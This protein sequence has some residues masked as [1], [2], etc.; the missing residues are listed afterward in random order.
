MNV[1]CFR[2][3]NNYFIKLHNSINTVDNLLYNEKGS[4]KGYSTKSEYLN[5]A[6]V[7]I[8]MYSWYFCYR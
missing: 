6:I 7:V 1:N 2:Y 8:T 4:I 5:L 3:F